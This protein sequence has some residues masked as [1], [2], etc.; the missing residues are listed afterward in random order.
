MGYPGGKAGAGV[1]QRIINEIP[2]HEVYIEAFAGGAAVAAR[3][4]R[5]A[6]TVLV[7]KHA[8]ALA[9]WLGEPGV[10]AVHGCAIDFL[11]SYGAWTGREFVYCDPPYVRAARRTRRDR[12]AHELDDAQH[13]RLLEVLARLPCM[14][15]VSGY[16]SD[17]YA[18]RLAGWR[19]V[20]FEAMTRGGMATECLWLNYPAPAALHDYRYL[21]EDYI[22]RQRIKRKVERWSGKLA[23]LDPL[24]RLAI[25]SALLGQDVGGRHSQ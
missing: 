19:L 9:P 3:K 11:A 13:E 4:R 1:Y 16:W 12:Y 23:G 24:E 18:R 8:P 14:V 25:V 20:E 6:R 15:A 22:D 2:P 10:E 17:L 7:D 5:A 21:G